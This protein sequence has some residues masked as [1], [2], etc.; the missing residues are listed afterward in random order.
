VALV[1]DI[2]NGPLDPKG[3]SKVEIVLHKGPDSTTRTAS[4]GADNTFDLGTIDPTSGV[5]LEA[6]LRNDSGAAV[7]Y[8]RTAMAAAF[9]GGANIVV[10]VRRPIAYIA[11]AVSRDADGNAQ[12]QGDHWTESPATFSDL[13]AGTILDGKTQLGPQLVMMVAAGP[14]L[15]MFT[16][17]TSD[18]DGTLIGPAK[19]APVSTAD[20]TVGPAMAA[21]LA[22]SL[23]DGAGTD[24]GST[25]VIGTSTQLFIVDTATGMARALTDGSFARVAIV[26]TDAGEV[27]AV[28]IKNRGLTTGPCS[29]TAELWWAPLSGGAAHMIAT[30]G[31]SDIA[32]DRGHAY[33]VDAC[34]GDFGEVTTAAT[35]MVRTFTG[36][37]TALA[38]SNE[39]AYVGI[40]TPP[41]T[42]SLVIAPTAPTTMTPDPPRVL[43]NEAAQ[44]VVNVVSSPGVQRLLDASS[45]VFLHLEVGAGG[46]Y[47]AVTTAASFHGAPVAAANFPDITMDTEELRVFAT[48]TGT[49]IQRYR[50]WCEGLVL[51]LSTDIGPWACASTAG[52]TAPARMSN[53]DHHIHS[54]TFQF[55]K[56]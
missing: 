24:D 53:L 14:S 21:T 49:I 3:F 52:Q 43:W 50:S 26:T 29:T 34:S 11:G 9:A 54:M 4:V 55:G 28:A 17:A 18:P 19:L 25:L 32:T 40:E 8:G 47:V 38:V 45:V 30:G 48:A 39:Q 12:T 33:Y 51:S 36:K 46:D 2:P 16:Q 1:L 35:R 10:P 7:G 6:T 56:K 37:P 27:A 15:Y 42:T 44:Q 31:F 5:A 23:L 20:H 41:A 13:S 22:G